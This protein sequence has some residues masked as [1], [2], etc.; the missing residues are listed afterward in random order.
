MANAAF[1]YGRRCPNGHIMDPNWDTCP[2]CAPRESAREQSTRLAGLA[3]PGGRRTTV[4]EVPPSEGGRETKVMPP[5]VEPYASGHE[6]AGDTRR[7]VGALITYTW[8]PE[9]QLF[10]VREGKTFIG[11]GDVS[12]EAFH[13]SCDVQIPEDRRMSGEH[14]LILCR[15]GTYEII[16]QTSSNG[17]F[18]DGKMLRANQSTEIPNYGKIETGST[19]WTFIQIEPPRE[20]IPVDPPPIPEPPGVTQVR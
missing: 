5:A 13:R 16:D 19:L 10:A 20:I 3:S 12:S 17:T 18:L 7:I 2:Y 9:G 6:G 1:R 8:R 14:A 15:H 11:S 4:G